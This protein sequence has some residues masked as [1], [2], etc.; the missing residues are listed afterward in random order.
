MPSEMLAAPF[1]DILDVSDAQ[2]GSTL[3]AGA[4]ACCSTAVPSPALTFS[5]DPAW[6]RQSSDIE[7]FCV[8]T[9]FASDDGPQERVASEV[10]GHLLPPLLAGEESDDDAEDDEQ[11]KRMGLVARRLALGRQEDDGE[12]EDAELERA[13]LRMGLAARRLAAQRSVAAADD[14]DEP[15]EPCMRIR[16][17]A[18]RLA[19]GRQEDNDGEVGGAE[20]EAAAAR[21]G[22]LARRYALAAGRSS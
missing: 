9:D 18:R 17:A 22:R 7:S 3:A 2:K 8:L 13:C 1:H 4:D 16:L 11:I 15:E 19:L 10:A 14:D 6:S 21:M 20:V 5:A 12:V